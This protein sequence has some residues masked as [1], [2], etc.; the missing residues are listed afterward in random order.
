MV[1]RGQHKLSVWEFWVNAW[2]K[3]QTRHKSYFVLIRNTALKKGKL[4]SFFK[5]PL[6]RP[7]VKAVG[8]AFIVLFVFLIITSVIGVFGAT[9]VYGE[10]GENELPASTFFSIFQD[11]P[12]FLMPWIVFKFIILALLTTFVV[13][14]IVLAAVYLPE[15][16]DSSYVIA[17]GVIAAAAVGKKII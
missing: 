14:V 6:S 1:A 5:F 16:G 7:D 12:W 3:F 13:L 4:H 11:S 9:K 10:M 17:S 8:I 2:R 15:G